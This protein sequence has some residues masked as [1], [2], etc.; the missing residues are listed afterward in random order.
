MSRSFLSVS[1]LV[2]VVCAMGLVASV[3]ACTKAADEA[4]SE[5]EVGTRP[6]KVWTPTAV[7]PGNVRV[8][9]WNIRNFPKDTM[10][11]PDGGAAEDEAPPTGTMRKVNETDQAMLVDMLDKLDFDVL[12][13]QEIND[14]A[15]FDAMLARLGAK[16]GRS[17]ASVYTVEWPHP[18][19][20]GIVVRKDRFRIE[21]PKE[22]PEI[23][24]RPT[25]RAGLS[26][27][28]V[29]TK[30]GGIDFGMLVLHLASGD[31]AGRATL[32]ATQASFAAKAIAARKAELGEQDFVVVGDFNTARQEQEM[33]VFDRTIGAEGSGLS[34]AENSSACTTYYTK[35]AQNP[36][37]QPS[38]IDHVYLASMNE[39]DE[40]VPIVAGAHCAER[41]CQPFESSSPE[42]G[43]SYWS[44][45][46]HC[47]VYFE[48][49][50]EDAD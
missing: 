43:T 47:P 41:S 13:V 46:D 8:A 21:A 28:L 9:T 27:H 15:A 35:G 6:S 20:V 25:M 30:Q 26:A 38:W 1:S 37:L 19:H 23:A 2:R 3:V 22:H 4:S 49:R 45:S 7:K 34:R 42:S 39:R 48:L 11:T 18:Q 14:P 12:G 31:S 33:P 10:G 50:D 5:A 36:I 32:R 24:T 29:S 17:Y 44:V 40:S 16:N